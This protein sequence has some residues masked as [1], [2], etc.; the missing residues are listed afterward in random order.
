M[1]N[2]WYLDNRRTRDRLRIRKNNSYQ[3]GSY[4]SRKQNSPLGTLRVYHHLQQSVRKIEDAKGDEDDYV[5]IDFNS[6]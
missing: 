1:R 3:S 5:E 6:L 4:T 2:R